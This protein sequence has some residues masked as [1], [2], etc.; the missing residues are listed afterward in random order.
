M[1]S[2]EKKSSV[3]IQSY[4]LVDLGSGAQHWLFF[5]FWFGDFIDVLQIIRVQEQTLP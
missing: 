3:S 4:L 2:S 1:H 5:L